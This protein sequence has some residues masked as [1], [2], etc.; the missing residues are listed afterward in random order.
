MNQ[1]TGEDDS[2]DAPLVLYDG[3]CALCNGLIR[4]LV[5]VDRSRQLRFAPLQGTT[6]RKIPDL[7]EVDETAPESILFVK[8]PDSAEPDVRERSDAVLDIFRELGG[9]WRLLDVFRMVPRGARDAVYRWI[10]RN[11]YRWFGRYESCPMPPPEAR[12]QFLP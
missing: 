10:A 12:N 1:E 9:P 11:R 4:L 7:P 8:N 2:I 3:H 5:R 6:A